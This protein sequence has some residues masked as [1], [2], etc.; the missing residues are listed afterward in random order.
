MAT[1]KKTTTKPAAKKAAPARTTTTRAAA[2]KTATAKAPAAKATTA[3]STTKTSSKTTEDGFRLS[4]GNVDLSADD[5]VEFVTDYAYATVGAGDRVVEVA[6]ELPQRLETLRKTRTEQAESFVT[7]TRTKVESFVK[8]APTKLQAELND[9]VDTARKEFETFAARGRKVVDTV[10]KN[11]TAKKALDAT[12]TARTQVTQA[13]TSL[14]KYVEQ[15]QDAVETAA[16][17]IG[18]RKTA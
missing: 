1:A 12:E 6:R 9:T 8:E 7:E 18:L 5:V 10:S 15:G 4:L 11:E 14:R 17:K 2:R 16:E 3:K 13:V